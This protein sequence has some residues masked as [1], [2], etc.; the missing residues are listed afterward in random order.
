MKQ[1][2]I[3]N[4]ANCG[5]GLMHNNQIHF[6]RMNIEQLIF[7]MGAISRAHGMELM[8]GN[9]APLAQIMGPNDDIAKP[10]SKPKTVLLCACCGMSSDILPAAVLLEE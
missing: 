3:E 2:E 8:M 6:Y 7:D 10:L 4:C 9:A 5:K 1:N